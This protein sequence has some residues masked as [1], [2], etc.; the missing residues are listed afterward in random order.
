M[1][2]H[3]MDMVVEQIIPIDSLSFHFLNINTFTF[4]VFINEMDSIK[5]I[6]SNKISCL[7]NIDFYHKGLDQLLKKTFSSQRKI[8]NK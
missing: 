1:E 3:F 2:N 7:R 5:R 6:V 8:K 4:V